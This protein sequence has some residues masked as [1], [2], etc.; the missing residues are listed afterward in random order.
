M[1]NGSKVY[2][3]AYDE[4]AETY[5][6]LVGELNYTSSIST[7]IIDVTTKSSN[8]YRDLLAEEGLQTNDI[9]CECIFNT[10]NGFEL[11][12][13]SSKNKTK[14]KVQI[15]N[16]DDETG[17]EGEYMVSS[18]SESSPMDSA[19]TASFTLAS[20]GEFSNIIPVVFSPINIST[21]LNLI[22]LYPGDPGFDSGFQYIS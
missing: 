19:L 14:L 10:E 5:E 9:N 20:T 17:I 1:Y 16:S 15:Y 7:D 22:H 12:R 3:R 21:G 4:V 18:F 8:S 2:L 6:V 11:F 13:T